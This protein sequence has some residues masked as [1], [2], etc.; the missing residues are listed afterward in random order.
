MVLRARIEI[1][2]WSGLLSVGVHCAAL[3]FLAATGKLTLWW[4]V[5]LWTTCA[6]LPLAL[7]VPAAGPRLRNRHIGLARRA[8]RMGL[9]YHIGLVSVFLLLRADILILNAMTTT[10]AVGLYA[11][12]VTLMELSRVAPDAVANIAMPQQLENDEKSA[13]AFTVK[14]TR[15]AALV[16]AVSVGF[17]CVAAPFAI[18]VVYGPAFAGSVGPLLGLAPGLWIIGASRPVGA[19]L[20]R[21]ERPLLNSATAVAALAVNVGLNLALIPSFGI[22]GSA[23]ASSIGYGML[24]ALQVA[25]FLRATRIPLR[26]LIPGRSDVLYLWGTACQMPF[27]RIG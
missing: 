6:A 14:A 3:V 7:L 15:I 24:A 26:R 4:V 10:V 12:A 2:N 1:N 16:A 18:P 8:L 22:I 17:M 11:V 20:L 25:W 13:A 5:A 9:R 23:L 27:L 21:L 19:F